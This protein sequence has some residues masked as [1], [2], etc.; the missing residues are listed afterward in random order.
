MK[1]FKA[2]M[3]ELV[4]LSIVDIAYGD[5]AIRDFS[6]FYDDD[7]TPKLHLFQNYSEKDQRLDT[8]YFSDF[9]V[10]DQYPHMSF[11]LRLIVTIS[12][13]QSAVER[14]FSIKNTWSRAANPQ[15]LLLHEGFVR[16]I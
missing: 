4:E 15:K 14:N 5:K 7:R 11:V 16:I 2:L 6:T 10:G 9:K 12:H 13:G 3:S 1:T 8:F